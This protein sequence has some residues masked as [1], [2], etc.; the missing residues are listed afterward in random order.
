[1]SSDKFGDKLRDKEKAD[2]DRYFAKQDAAKLEKLKEG[3]ER[4]PD[5]G[6]PKCPAPLETAQVDDVTVDLCRK[7]GGV[8]LDAGELEQ[9]VARES[10][11]WASKL[12][13]GALSRK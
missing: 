4:E 13:R 11:G 2:E 9:I 10:E 6:C 12:I 8:W 1:M 7:C 5:G 3:E